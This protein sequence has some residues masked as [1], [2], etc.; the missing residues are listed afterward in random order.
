M[1]GTSDDKAEETDAQRIARLERENATLRELLE[2]TEQQAQAALFSLAQVCDVYEDDMLHWRATAIEQGRRLLVAYVEVPF[3][4]TQ[5]MRHN[6]PAQRERL[7][8][9][10]QQVAEVVG[11]IRAEEQGRAH[12]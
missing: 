5:D 9:T 3:E 1:P 11:R 4:D 2:G 8:W 10:N 6:T 7:A 12:A